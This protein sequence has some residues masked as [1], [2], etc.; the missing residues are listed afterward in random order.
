M[1]FEVLQIYPLK[2]ILSSR[3]VRKWMYIN[4]VSKHMHSQESQHDA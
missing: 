2:M 4:L 1:E 3:L